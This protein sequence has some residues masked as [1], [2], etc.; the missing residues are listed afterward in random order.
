M[1]SAW[2]LH[3]VACFFAAMGLVALTSP[4]TVLSF[5]GTK[6][7]T[8]DGRSEVRAVYGG[9]GVGIAVLLF[10]ATGLIG[11]ADSLLASTCVQSGVF[12]T[13]AVSM[14]GMALGRIVSAVVDG[15][16]GPYVWLFFFVEL[17][18]AAALLMQL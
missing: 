12:V 3:L 4:E 6:V 2:L 8:R 17:A 11:G 7:L 1:A 5:F 9:Y 14:M 15:K 16:P 13:V 10:G 18:L